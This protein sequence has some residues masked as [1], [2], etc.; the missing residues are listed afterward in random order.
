MAV[1]ILG[2]SILPVQANLPRHNPVSGGIAVIPLTTPLAIKPEVQFGD[3]QV[4]V[5]RHADG[6]HAY[7]GLPCDMLPGKYIILIFRPD[8]TH[9]SIE[10][11]VMPHPP[12]LSNIDRRNE[13]QTRQD[14]HGVVSLPEPFQVQSVMNPDIPRRV[15]TDPALTATLATNFVFQAPV[16]STWTV[17]YGKILVNGEFQCHDYLSYLVPLHHPVFAP[18]HGVVI[19]REKHQE[20]H[21]ILIAHAESVVSILGNLKNVFVEVGQT[22][23]RGDKLGEA[24]MASGSS[25][26]RLDWAVALNGYRVDPLQFSSTP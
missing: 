25:Q 6:W 24:A 13:P 7:V 19:G 11:N 5:A 8:Q 26:G 15:E 22:V 23:Q 3:R 12:P 17:D 18:A 10:W 14:R 16:E 21:L 20:S 4:H 2:W 9:T 1:L